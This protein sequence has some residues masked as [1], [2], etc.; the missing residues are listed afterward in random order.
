LG[1][2]G[3]GSGHNRARKTLATQSSGNGP[4]STPL[5]LVRDHH[6]VRLTATRGP[7]ADASRGAER[8]ERALRVGPAASAAARSSS[9]TPRPW[10]LERLARQAADASRARTTAPRPS[11]RHCG[12]PAAASEAAV[13]T[14]YPRRQIHPVRRTDLT[15]QKQLRRCTIREFRLCDLHRH[16]SNGQGIECD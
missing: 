13:G 12:A 11:C 4:L 14:I 7:P 16:S 1:W 9:A 5:H 6:L 15:L 10:G 3:G 8:L 2:V